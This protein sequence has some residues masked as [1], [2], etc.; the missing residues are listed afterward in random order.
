MVKVIAGVDIGMY[1]LQLVIGA[2]HQNH[3]LMLL[4]LLLVTC[5]QNSCCCVWLP[6]MVNARSS[7]SSTFENATVELNLP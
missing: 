7:S 6:S 5:T 3:V 4:L 1:N 2:K